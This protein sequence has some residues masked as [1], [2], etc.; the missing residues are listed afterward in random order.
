MMK[1]S[2]NK[3]L[4]NSICTVEQLKKYAELSDDVER[5]LKRIIQRHP[6]R[7][8]PYYM[9]LIDWDNP[10]DPIKKMAVPSLEEFNLE[11]SYDTSGEAE[12]TKL[13]G[14]QH[15]YSET[16]LIL[17]TNRCAI[18]CR[19]C[20][21]KR[22]IGLPSAE[23]IK[24]FEDAANYVRQ[25]KEINNVL[26]TGGD[27]LVLSNG[28]IEN[29][30]L[31]LSDIP[32]LKFIRFGSRTPVTLPSRFDDDELLNILREHSRPDRRIYVVTQFNYPREITKKSIKAVDNL[33]KSGVV[34][35]NQT[36]LLKGVNDYPRTL[37][38]LQ[39]R[40]VD[41]GV[42]PY[43][44]F[45]CRPVK[46]V[47]YSFQIPICKGIDIIETAKKSCN[48]HSKRFK[49]IMSHKTG[50]IEILGIVDNEIYFKYHQAKNRKNLG[51]IFRRKVDSK[52]SWLDDFNVKVSDIKNR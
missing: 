9:S 35:N 17:A 10:S 52:A 30:L 27:P 49:Y 11:G 51:K 1:M 38:K 44:V 19:H 25:H 8:T 2:W 3:K 14:L 20:F 4:E 47:K 45:Q 34:L 21:R 23:V 29:L 41:I 26:I 12:N 18:Y 32:H 31:L 40:L 5:Q 36:V 7:I 43:Y 24:R 28:V 6:M 46:R 15:K 13:P 22:L 33:I 48:G 16:A 37:A 50:K 39:N 42:N